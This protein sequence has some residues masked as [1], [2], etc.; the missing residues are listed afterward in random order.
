MLEVELARLDAKQVAGSAGH[1]PRLVRSRRDEDL[2]QA[3]D[4]VAQRVIC[5]VEALFREELA[6]QSLARD[7]TVRAQQEQPE[8]R[9]LLRSPNRD[10]SAVHP[11][12][13]RTEDPELEAARCHRAQPECPPPATS[14]PGVVTPLGQLWDITAGRF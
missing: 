4:L 7:D 1:E 5:R 3:R 9:A 11:N 8:Q 2:A 10:R 6:D 14:I 13:E 12:R